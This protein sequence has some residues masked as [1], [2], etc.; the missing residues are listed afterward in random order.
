MAIRKTRCNRCGAAT[1]VTMMSMFNNERLCMPC[2][3]LERAH[4]AYPDA[5]EAE[6]NAVLAGARQF[7]GIGLPPGLREQSIAA[8]EERENTS[9]EDT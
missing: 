8:R 7:P 5:Q 3:D 1:G 2:I 4:P 6:R 9:K